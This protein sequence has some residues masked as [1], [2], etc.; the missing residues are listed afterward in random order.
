MQASEGAW[1]ATRSG[2]WSTGSR[3]SRK[4]LDRATKA[5]KTGERRNQSPRLPNPFSPQHAPLSVPRR[6]GPRRSPRISGLVR[7]AENC[8][9][10]RTTDAQITRFGGRC[11]RLIR[12]EFRRLWKVGRRTTRK[13]HRL[14][15]QSNEVSDER[16]GKWM[17][18]NGR[19]Q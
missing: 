4:H 12:K 17:W 13:K 3:E 19:T 10:E 2:L 8:C 16:F 5:T 18:R 11:S 9:S 1:H 6:G 14:P 15:T 7:A